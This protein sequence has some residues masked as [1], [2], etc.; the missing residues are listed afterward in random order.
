MT[1][2]PQRPLPAWH[3][4]ESGDRWFQAV[5]RFCASASTG[6]PQII[7]RWD[8]ASATGLISLATQARHQSMILLWELPHEPQG[9]LW[10]LDAV[11]SI[12]RAGGGVM[13]LVHVPPRC[14]SATALLALEAGAS[15]L[16]ED[17]W[18]LQKV[19][20]RLSSAAAVDQALPS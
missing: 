1:S 11:A 9:M 8:A 5:V 17:L 19:S 14:P 6:A 4:V 13:Q 12:K 7:R 2:D 15:L 16:V 18:S 10:T 3:I 20:N